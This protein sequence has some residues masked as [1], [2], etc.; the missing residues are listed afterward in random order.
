MISRP[1]DFR[2]RLEWAAGSMPPPYHYEYTIQVEA[3]QGLITFFPD[4]P[5]ADTPMW[6]ETFVVD[7]PE[8]EGLFQLMAAKKVFR[9]TWQRQQEPTTGGSR[10]WLEVTCG[11]I[12][13]KVPYD[14][15][16]AEQKALDEVYD[17]VR[18]L[19]PRDIWEMLVSRRE[20]YELDHE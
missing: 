9:D 19:I 12:V 2:F 6:E 16:Y 15:E 4:Y 10:S 20:Q 5:S 7:E 1:D 18:S 8:M 13:Y 11:K 3:G 14:L 17:S